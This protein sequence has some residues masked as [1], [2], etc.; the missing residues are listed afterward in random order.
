[1]NDNT[2]VIRGKLIVGLNT[3]C[4]VTVSIILEEREF[5]VGHTKWWGAAIFYI[6]WDIF[7]QINN[8]MGKAR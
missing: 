1:M 6:P 5:L 4:G 8:Y 2:L 3:V 7:L